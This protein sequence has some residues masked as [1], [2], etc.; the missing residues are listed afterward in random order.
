MSVIP[1]KSLITF[2]FFIPSVVS[3]PSLSLVSLRHG[4]VDGFHSVSHG[5]LVHDL[6]RR[7]LEIDFP[8]VV[9]FSVRDLHHAAVLLLS[10][11]LE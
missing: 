9:S 1:L 8:G 11:V 2:L 4:L 7:L 5:E 3:F 10:G 6:L